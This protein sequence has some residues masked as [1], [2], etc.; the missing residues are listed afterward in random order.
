MEITRI[1]SYHDTRFSQTVLYQHGCF[2][3]D[4]KPY[5]VEI[6]GESEAVIRG[7]LLDNYPAVIEEFRFYTPHISRFYD[8]N[9]KLIVQFADKPV[10]TLALADIQPSQFYVDRDKIA[11]IGTFIHKSEDIIIQVLK[12]GDRYISLDGHTR[13]YYAV[14]QGWPYVRAVEEA[15]A[16]YINGFVEAAISRGIYT[17]MDIVPLSHADYEEKWNKY[18]DNFFATKEG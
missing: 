6:I 16:D 9:H 7:E 4:G 12:S 15:S 3:V 18:C 8:S 13:L 17:P 2:L 11:A 5:E 14:I 10:I 1:N